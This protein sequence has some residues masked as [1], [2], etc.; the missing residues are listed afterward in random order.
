MAKALSQPNRRS[1]GR[2]E[3]AVTA[4][5]QASTIEVRISAGPTRIVARST[6]FPGSSPGPFLE[7]EPVQE[8]DCRAETEPE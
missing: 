7:P 5:P 4:S 3:K 6:G 1:I 2:F 8:M